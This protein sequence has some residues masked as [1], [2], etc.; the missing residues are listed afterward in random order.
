LLHLAQRKE[1]RITPRRNY[2]ARHADDR[3]S[4]RPT[5]GPHTKPIFNLSISQLL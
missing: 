5:L 2:L 3:Q 4:E 1:L